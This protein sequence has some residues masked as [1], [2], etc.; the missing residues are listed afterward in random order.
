MGRV[1]FGTRL[2]E[3]K[4]VRDR[5]WCR[6]I[7]GMWVAGVAACAGLAHAQDAPVDCHEEGKEP[8][9]GHLKASLARTI[10]PPRPRFAEADAET[11]VVHC[12][13]D[14]ELDP[15]AQTISGANTVT[16]TS[17]ADGVT[18][19]TLDLRSNLVVDGVTVN[20]EA[21]AFSRPGDTV[22]VALDRPYRTGEGF[23]VGVRYHGSPLR[24]GFGSFAWETHGTPPTTVVSTLS[25]PWYAYTWWPCK[26]AL[27]DKFTMDMWVTVPDWMIVAS[28][29]RLE[30]TDA[31]AAGKRRFRWRESY[32]IAPYLVSLAATNYVSWSYPHSHAGG[33]MPVVFYAYPES[34]ATVRSG[35]ADLMTQLATFSRPDV[36]G[37]YPFVAEKYGIAQFPWG[38]GMEHQTITSQGAFL[39]WLNA[40]ELAHQWWGDMVTCATWHDIWLNEGFATFAEALYEE[41]RPGGSSA[42]YFNRMAQRR[43][44]SYGGSVYVY[45]AT[46]TGAI[47]STTN[48]YNKGAWALHMLRHVL[49]DAVFFDALAAYRATY[50]G[51][52]ATTEGFRAICESVSGREL[53]WWF[54]EWIYGTGAPY[55][56]YGWQTARIGSQDYVRLSVQ[57]YQTAYPVFTMPIDIRA[58]TSAGAATHVIWNDAATEWYVLPTSGSVTALQFDPGPWILRGA[59]ENVSYVNGPPKLVSMTPGPGASVP[60]VPAVSGVTLGFSEPITWAAGDFAV[61]G[62]RSGPVPATAS[63]DVATHAVTLAFPVPLSAGDAYTVIVGDGVRSAAAGLS[64]DGEVADSSHESSLPSGDGQP[65]GASVLRFSIAAP[66]DLDRDGDVDGADFSIFS[67]CFNGTG[68]PAPLGCPTAD[69]NEDGGVDGADFAIFS[70]CFNGSGNAPACG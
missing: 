56:R 14:L 65:G 45:D 70:S 1:S 67:A 33:T 9:C 50:A 57:Q 42:A 58:T 15:V 20:G 3:E 21:A 64:L 8:A 40:H 17:L 5:R 34:E 44:S 28:N 36:F 23:T 63:Y 10:A 62:L 47:F 54:S 22:A 68:S 52:S 35:T 41:K 39:S 43:P 49:G 13:L 18:M 25:Q 26:E 27:D 59:A 31:P 46:N 6:L 7:A 32:P 37:E 60:A 12:F 16:A 30:A 53:G 11:D 66:G 24:E 4:R 19:F 51:N 61:A 29:G 69:L 55:Y 2:L 48:V 38:G